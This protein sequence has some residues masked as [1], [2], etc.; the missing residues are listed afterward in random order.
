[1]IVNNKEE[2]LHR[3]FELRTKIR[4][5]ELSETHIIELKSKIEELM[6]YVD[7]FGKDIGDE[8]EHRD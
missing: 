3:V 2:L 8:F 4:T 6:D 5:H 7:F 1:M